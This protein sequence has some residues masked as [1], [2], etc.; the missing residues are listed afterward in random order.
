MINVAGRAHDD[1]LG[2]VS[3]GMNPR[4]L[5]LAEQGSGGQT[6][7]GLA[8]SKL[9]EA[10]LGRSDFVRDGGG[11]LA[12]IRRRGDGPADDEVVRTVADRLGGRRHARLVVPRRARRPH[13]RHD[14]Q[15]FRPAGP[16]DRSRLLRRS[17]HSVEP[18]F[19][20]QAR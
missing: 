15:E 20:R 1:V 9:S 17:D 16:A 12:G 10:A 3:Q 7:V 4:R 14:N 19:F 2:A 6:A 8:A 11:C 18:G 13:A 5:M